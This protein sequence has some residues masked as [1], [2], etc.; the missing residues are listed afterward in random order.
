MHDKIMDTICLQ[1][2]DILIQVMEGS[3]YVLPYGHFI[4]ER[5]NDYTVTI[6]PVSLGATRGERHT[7]LT[8]P[9]KLRL[10]LK[11]FN[12]EY[13]DDSNTCR[14]KLFDLN[15]HY[16]EHITMSQI[17]GTSPPQ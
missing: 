6:S 16:N 11:T 10:N 15:Q 4:V 14:F 13:K 7:R 1:K 5:V 8:D 3:N 9:F 2:G 17:L 12:Y